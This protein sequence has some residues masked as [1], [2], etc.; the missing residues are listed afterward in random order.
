MP[1]YTVHTPGYLEHVE[2]CVENGTHW[3]APL[4]SGY[5]SGRKIPPCGSVVT[6]T[7]DGENIIVTD[8]H[9]TAFT[10][11]KKKKPRSVKPRLS[12]GSVRTHYW[13]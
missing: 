6:V 3:F 7:V 4:N 1:T 10:E 12:A 8:D 9:G 13:E 2:V 5:A 11:L